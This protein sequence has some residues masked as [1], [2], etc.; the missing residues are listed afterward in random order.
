[1]SLI[2]NKYMFFVAN[3]RHYDMFFQ[4]LCLWQ[5]TQRK[6]FFREFRSSILKHSLTILI[7][8]NEKKG[9]KNSCKN[10]KSKFTY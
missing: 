1:M 2:S 5:Y 3:K 4:G 10:L 6:L 9:K 7:N 8:F